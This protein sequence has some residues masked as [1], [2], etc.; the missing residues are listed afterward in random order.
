MVP[1]R[2]II[3]Q[4]EL[5]LRSIAERFFKSWPL[6]LA[7]LV[8]WTFIGGLFQIM[9]PVWHNTSMKVQIEKPKGVNDAATMVASIPLFVKPDDSY[10]VNLKVLLTSY[11][12]LKEAIERTGMNIQYVK[13]G[14]IL[15]TDIYGRS[16]IRIELDS[17]YMSFEDHLTPYNTPF[18]VRFLNDNLYQVYAEG[19]YPVTEIEFEF[20]GEFAFNEWVT[21]DKIKFKVIKNDTLQNS[22]I[23]LYNNLVEDAFGFVLRSSRVWAIQYAEDISVEAADVEAT[24][25]NV[26]ILAEAPAKQVAFFNNLVEL[27]IE[28]H[29]ESKTE[30]L[31]KAVDF[32]TNE[33]DRMSK[34]LALSEDTIQKFKSEK[35]ITNFGREGDLVV[36][37]STK[38]ENQKVDLL[39][40]QKY[41][42]YLKDFLQDNDNYGGL[43]SP[44][45]FG[46]EDRLI[47]DLTTELVE[48]QYEKNNLSQRSDSDNPM[49]AQ[50]DNKISSNKEVIVQS[51]TGFEK[52][53]SMLIANVDAELRKL[54]RE[55]RTLPEE[56]RDLIRLDRKYRL[57]EKLYSS[58]IEKKSEAELARISIGSDIKII[59]PAYKSSVE[60]VLPN[61]II[62][63]IAIVLMSI[64]FGILAVVVRN[65]F[66]SKMEDFTDLSK[67]A[68]A[69][70]VLGTLENTNVL[71]PSVLTGFPDSKTSEELNSILYNTEIKS[72]GSSKVIS[73]SGYSYNVGASTL[74][75]LLATRAGLMGKK[76]TV[77]DLNLSKP[78]LHEKMN[79]KNSAGISDVISGSASLSEA[80]YDS[81]YADVKII[82][83]GSIS[84]GNVREKVG[85][86]S[87][88]N[89]LSEKNDF[90][91]V[92]LEPFGLNAR[93][94]MVQAHCNY[95]IIAVRR[96]HSSH[97]QLER[98]QDMKVSGSLSN[99]G[100][101]AT[102]TFAKGY[103]ILAR[104]NSKIYHDPKI[105]LLT[106]LKLLIKRV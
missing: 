39:V 11:P 67:Y 91:F 56:E 20:E 49:L 98:L 78:S 31:D 23:T 72:K 45:A 6:L 80:E 35:G 33:V 1:E 68:S 28:T 2:E 27:V 34:M 73:I 92:L 93:A 106:H 66:S 19:E 57:N 44:Q 18:Y 29:M 61:P 85:I 40:R 99:T 21:F 70:P 22:Q 94:L 81:G 104:R 36:E 13:K 105:G 59:A 51:I 4:E 38:M 84:K 101:V 14:V 69:I 100:L 87:I 65:L 64:I 95:N 83:A 76:V 12:I 32:L 58:L 62:T 16:P 86:A 54:D 8:F 102:D 97:S 25:Y 90:V 47:S 7:V 96:G 26:S 50:L 52:S 74:T 71:L 9:F 103:K 88:L 3:R 82:P 53:N 48:L 17:T 79:V 43:I 41:Y 75:S 24:V 46:I 60:P 5:D 42:K 77:V 63:L 10:N 30:S 89:E 55:S 37:Q 15:D